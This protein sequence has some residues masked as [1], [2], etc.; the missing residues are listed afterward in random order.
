MFIYILTDL[1]KKIFVHTT[2][3]NGKQFKFGSGDIS[4]VEKMRCHD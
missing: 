3:I 2:P 4:M 1:T